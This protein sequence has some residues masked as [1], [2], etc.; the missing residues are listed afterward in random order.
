MG[1]ILTRRRVEWLTSRGPSFWPPWRRKG[2]HGKKIDGSKNWY[3][4]DTRGLRQGI[5]PICPT[6][7]NGLFLVVSA[8]ADKQVAK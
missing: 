7:L 1:C 5:Q 8:F 4:P 3:R 2:T 6:P